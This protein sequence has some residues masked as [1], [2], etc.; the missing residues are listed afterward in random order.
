MGAGRN[1]AAKAARVWRES[2]IF[3]TII[4]HRLVQRN[5][6]SRA[7]QGRGEKGEDSFFCMIAVALH[8]GTTVPDKK[9]EDRFFLRDCK[10][11]CRAKKLPK[12][13]E[14]CTQIFSA[15]RLNQVT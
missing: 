8:N 10:E 3:Y 1:Y 9:G 7:A 4:L 15:T 6:A 2:G 12:R 11:P 14:G 13:R 5:D